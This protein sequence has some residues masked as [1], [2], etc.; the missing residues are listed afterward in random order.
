M[1][2]QLWLAVRLC[3]VLLC[4]MSGTGRLNHNAFSATQ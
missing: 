1:K 2:L 3:R 4:G